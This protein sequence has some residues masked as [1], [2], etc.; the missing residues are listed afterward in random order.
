[1]TPNEPDA[2]VWRRLFGSLTGNSAVDAV[3]VGEFCDT[4]GVT[5]AQFM[6]KLHTH[7]RINQQQEEARSA[8]TRVVG[9]Q[10]ARMAPSSRPRGSSASKCRRCCSFAPMT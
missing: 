1:M 4:N 5:S 10:M 2:E 7:R 6:G 3:V 9:L 8:S